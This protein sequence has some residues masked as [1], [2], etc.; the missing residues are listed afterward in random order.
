MA[1]DPNRWTIKTQEAFSAATDAA[2]SNSNPEVTDDHLL[3]ALLRQD[4]GVVLPILTRVGTQPLA[5][6]NAADEAVAKLPK[7][8]GSEVRLSRQV[9]QT[10]DVA[11]RAR[12]E[13]GDE[14]LS[15]EHL[16]L[17]LAERLAL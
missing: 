17:A 1:L 2:R 9:Q 7:A 3:A 12:V 13:M 5:L 8:Y 14:Y 4:D 11:D 16:L 10:M 15:T 6:R